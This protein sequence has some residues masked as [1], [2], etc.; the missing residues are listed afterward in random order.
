MQAAIMKD[1]PMNNER[2]SLT[3]AERGE[4]HTGNQ[5]KGVYREK[6]YSASDIEGM[7]TYFDK[8]IR[9]KAKPKPKSLKDNSS[10]PIVSVL[11]LNVL[12]MNKTVDDLPDEDQARLLIVRDW[13][14]NT[15]NQP[16]FQ[17]KVYEECTNCEWDA[18]YLDPNKYTTKT[19]ANGQTIRTRGRVMNKKARQNIM[20]IKDETQEPN[21]IE[22]KGRI[23]NLRDRETLFNGL[24][25]LKG[26]LREALKQCGSDSE[27]GI[28]VVEGN[29]YY[30]LKTTG[31]GFHG[32][33]ERVVVICLTVGGG[34]NFP[35]RFQWFK[36]RMPIGKPI[37][38]FLNDGDLYIMSHKAV[39]CDWKKGSKYTLRHAAGAKKYL[40]LAKWEKR[41]AKKAEAKKPA[42][43]KP[44]AKKPATAKKTVEKVEAQPTSVASAPRPQYLNVLD[45]EIFTSVLV[46]VPENWKMEDKTINILMG[47]EFDDISVG[48]GGKHELVGPIHIPTSKV[49][50]YVLV[51]KK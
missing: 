4:N 12:S 25:S 36:D 47:Q 40:S 10:P 24:E 20:F 34:G 6:G 8:M 9:E 39:G 41:A 13:A 1:H 27:V 28:N 26:Q 48:E 17:K 19:N 5:M 29:R 32:D 51:N 23:E 46:E 43:K 37:D 3:C 31:I 45:T 50:T 42:A 11:D 30:D 14:K 16:D 21:Y 35:M 2:I 18:K 7:G 38:L 15:L 44:A 22:G 49:K 33:T